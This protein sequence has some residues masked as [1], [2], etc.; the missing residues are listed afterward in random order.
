MAYIDLH[1]HSNCSDGVLSPEELVTA[2][3]QA[4]LVAISLTD[5]DNITG[6]PRAIAAGEKA[7][8]MVIPGVELSV[9]WHDWHDVHLL[10]YDIDIKNAELLKALDRFATQRANRNLEIISSINR[11]LVQKG[12]VQLTVEEV[13]NL[14]DGV[15]G[16]PHIA[17]ALIARNHVQDM[18]EAFEQ[19]LVPCNVPK[20]YWPMADAIIAI[21]NAGGIAVLAHPTSISHDLALLRK[22]IEELATIGLDGVEVYNS[23]AS[24]TEAAFLQEVAHNLKLITTA[25]SDFHGISP[26]DRIG[27]GRNGIRFSDAL[28][29][30]FASFPELVDYQA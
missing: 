10:G 9:A 15:L 4:G 11:K 30:P 2:A 29:R 13:T 28:L 8:I 22:T 1:T 27:K 3:R 17:R 20:T 21:H 18:D 6:V 24:E 26:E 16:R 25:G 19:Y 12:L 14:A 7:G 5:H 23:M